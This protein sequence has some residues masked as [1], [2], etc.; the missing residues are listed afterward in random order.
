M[1]DKLLTATNI[2]IGACR[3]I[4]STFFTSPKKLTLAQIDSQLAEDMAMNYT[5]SIEQK[6]SQIS[7]EHLNFQDGCGWTILHK[8]IYHKQ[9][10][11][12]ETIMSKMSDEQISRQT[13]QGET[14]LHMA[15]KYSDIEIIKKILSRM[16][17][18]T[19]S[20]E[21]VNG[22]NALHYAIQSGTVKKVK[23]LLEK[24]DND[25]Y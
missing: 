10:S 18:E 14:V 22:M 15:T 23:I 11:V 20:L 16:S 4:Y 24:I 7:D 2:T 6:V 1:A 25:K 8:A 13:N 3:D 5:S 12:I 9:H 21:T 19:A 17:K